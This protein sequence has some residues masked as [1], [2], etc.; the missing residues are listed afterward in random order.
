MACVVKQ[1]HTRDE[2]DLIAAGAEW[3]CA[4]CDK[5]TPAPTPDFSELEER[6]RNGGKSSKE[7]LRI[8][9]WNADGIKLKMQELAARVKELDIEVCD[10]PGVQTQ[11]QGQDH[12][13][14]RLQLRQSSPFRRQS[15][16]RF[17]D[18]HQGRRRV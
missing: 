18:L 11:S 15:R 3:D 10:H 9:Q 12:Q 8:L 5:P 7:A 14:R 1:G 6:A 16:R 17:A 13:D 2:V 4:D